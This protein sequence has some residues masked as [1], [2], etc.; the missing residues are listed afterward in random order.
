MPV[1]ACEFESHLGHQTKER[2]KRIF[3]SLPYNDSRVSVVNTRVQA[4]A[5][6]C[7]AILEQG[8]IPVCPVVAGHSIMVYKPTTTFENWL[9]YSLTFLNEQIDELNV[10]QIPG[11]DFSNGV[12]QELEIAVKLGIP[13]KYIS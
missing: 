11:W 7:A 3:V 1:V 10:L 8:D 5:L 12:L 9:E 4:A 13:I 2:M 6:H